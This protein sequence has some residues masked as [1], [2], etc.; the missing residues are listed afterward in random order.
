[1]KCAFWWF[2]K[3]EYHQSNVC[4]QIQSGHLHIL[5]WCLWYSTCTMSQHLDICSFL[6]PVSILLSLL[7]SSNAGSDSFPSPPCFLW[8]WCCFSF[9]YT[10]PTRTIFMQSCIMGG[11]WPPPLLQKKVQPWL[12]AQSFIMSIPLLYLVALAASAATIAATAIL[13]IPSLNR[14]FSGSPWM[15][16]HNASGDCSIITPYQ[17]PDKTFSDIMAFNLHSQHSTTKIP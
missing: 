12:V 17:V 5:L 4:C 15:Y 3:T 6:F 16:H 9:S 8:I 2:I 13:G 1:M 10:Q 11:T 7:L 14:T